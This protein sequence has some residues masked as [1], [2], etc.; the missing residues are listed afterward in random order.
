[1]AKGSKAKKSQ[2]SRASQLKP[3][4]DEKISVRQVVK[5]ERTHK[6]A[7]AFFL[8]L[9]V[10]LGIAFTSYLFTWFQDQDLVRK[11]ASILFSSSEQRAANLLGNLGAYVSYAFFSKGFGLASYF[12]CSFFFIL[13]ANWLFRKKIFSVSRNLRYVL[14]GL[15]YFSVTLSFFTKGNSFSWGGAFGDMVSDWLRG[16]LGWIGTAAL[17]LVSGLAYIIWRF[18]PFSKCLHCRLK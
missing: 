14:V 12:I 1:M 5:D 17:L 11:G 7:G 9:A 10:Y 6:I 8:L 16:F 3:E 13:G 18:N 4:K 15:V 2:S